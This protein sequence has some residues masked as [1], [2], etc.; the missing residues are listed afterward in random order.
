MKPLWLP[1]FAFLLTFAACQQGEQ[2][3]TTQ[4]TSA[5]DPATVEQSI[6]DAAD[7]YEQ[8][9]LAGD[10]ATLASFY[11]DD[12]ILLPPFMPKAEG[13][14]AVTAAYQQ[15][16]AGGNPTSASIDPSTIVVS[17][18]G[19]LAYEVGSFSFTGPGP[20]GSEMTDTGK[21][22]AIWKPIE[23][24]EWKIAVDTWNSDGM[25]SGVSG[26]TE[27]APAPAGQ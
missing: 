16:Y 21:Y 3:G 5:V 2:A 12:A 19:D 24:G 22:V 17:E 6:R 27:T 23:T 14:A 26:T 11:A 9:A 1:I 15:M 13:I 10:V 18:S 7:R 8:A 20:N 25:P 4:E